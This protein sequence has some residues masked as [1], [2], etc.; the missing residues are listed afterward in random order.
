MK[1]HPQWP[2]E[3]RVGEGCSAKQRKLNRAGVWGLWWEELSG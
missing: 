2:R 3:E 1:Q